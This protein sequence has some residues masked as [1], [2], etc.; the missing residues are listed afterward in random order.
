MVRI[1]FHSDRDRVKGNYLLATSSI[2]RRLRGQVFEV[3]E[4]DLKLLDE[5]RVPYS[6]IPNPDLNESDE[7]VR[8]LITVGLALPEYSRT[9]PTIRATVISARKVSLPQK[10]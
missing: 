8:D 9:D 5:C 7:E 10:D 3:A 1:K 4:H 2:T 6:I